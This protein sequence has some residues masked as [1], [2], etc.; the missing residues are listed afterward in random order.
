MCGELEINKTV[1]FP[2]NLIIEDAEKISSDYLV[3]QFKNLIL[4]GTFP[5]G[6]LLPTENTFCEK[7]GISRST[8]REAFK[9]LSTYGL[10]TR[11]NHGTYVNDSKDFSS[12][13]VMDYRFEESSIIEILEFRKIFEAESAY[14]A[15]K[16][17]TADDIKE[18]KKIMINMENCENDP[19]SLSLNDVTFHIMIA[20]C[21]HNRLLLSVMK[22]ISDTYYKGIR[23][24]FELVEEIEG[25]STLISTIYN[26]DKIFDAILLKDSETAAKAMREHMDTILISIEDILKKKEKEKEKI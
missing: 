17:A 11:T 3:E 7:L 20:K 5:S 18:L 4:S 22:L 25:K 23:S 24:Q 21:T 13:L 14:L 12:S 6:Y 26:H 10:I 15:A 8:L 9:V 16:N 1:D 19:E 2:Y